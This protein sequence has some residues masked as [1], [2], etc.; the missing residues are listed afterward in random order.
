M[1][2]KGILV[3]FDLKNDMVTGVETVNMQD[4]YVSTEELLLF[5][6]R[7]HVQTIYVSEMESE[8]TIMFSTYGIGVKTLSSLEDDRLFESLYLFPPAF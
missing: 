1:R 8:M 7:K 6:Q 4:K 3:I 2:E 5:I